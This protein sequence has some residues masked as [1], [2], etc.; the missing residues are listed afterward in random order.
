MAKLV[1]SSK[2]K[3]LYKA[4]EGRID[5]IRRLPGVPRGPLFKGFFIQGLL[6]LGGEDKSF[7][8]VFK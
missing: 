2:P 5:L 3:K 6:R 1:Q 7:K 8:G 4:A